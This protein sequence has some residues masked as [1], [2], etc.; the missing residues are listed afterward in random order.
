MGFLATGHIDV[1]TLSNLKLPTRAFSTLSHQPGWGAAGQELH[2]LHLSLPGWDLVDLGAAGCVHP[3]WW[4]GKPCEQH[5]QALSLSPRDTHT[6]KAGGVEVSGRRNWRKLNACYWTGIK[7]NTQNLVSP[8][9][10]HAKRRVFWNYGWCGERPQ[11]SISTTWCVT[12][13]T[14][15]KS[16]AHL[17]RWQCPDSGQVGGWWHWHPDQPW[18]SPWLAGEVWVDRK[19]SI[20]LEAHTGTAWVISQKTQHVANYCVKKRHWFT[21]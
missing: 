13:H 12:T 20:T 3:V 6:S 18:G 2:K 10:K 21:V 4:G 19:A 9:N 8:N 1:S 17:G 5:W 11:V 16:P 14:V 7:N 15:S